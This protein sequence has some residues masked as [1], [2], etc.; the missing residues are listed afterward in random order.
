MGSVHCNSFCVLRVREKF[1]KKEK[2]E[3]KKR[4]WRRIRCILI[5]ASTKSSFSDP[6]HSLNL[7]TF[8]SPIFDQW[9]REREHQCLTPNARE[10]AFFVVSKMH[11]FL[12]FVKFYTSDFRKKKMSAGDAKIGHPAPAFN[13]QALVN[14]EF[15]NVQLSD[16]K[17]NSN[18]AWKTRSSRHREEQRV[19]IIEPLSL[20]LILAWTACSVFCL[21][22]I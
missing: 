3:G 12:E 18:R 17:G 16:Y 1:R 7:K 6:F 20:C 13:A 4:V 5:G 8:I 14:G 22:R 11:Y 15:K 9:E 10:N 19:L 21:L 2:C